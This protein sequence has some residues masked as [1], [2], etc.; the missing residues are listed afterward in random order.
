MS[1]SRTLARLR[2]ANRARGPVCAASWRTGAV[3]RLQGPDAGGEG[4]PRM[5]PTEGK[6]ETDTER[7]KRL[8]DTETHK[9]TERQ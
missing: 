2:I 8:K 1:G 7:N 9:E 6:T 4:G 3:R 5:A